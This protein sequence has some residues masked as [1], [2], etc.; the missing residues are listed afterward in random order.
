MILSVSLVLSI[1]YRRSL[2]PSAGLPR[3]TRVGHGA[4]L[5]EMALNVLRGRG[6]RGGGMPLEP[7]AIGEAD[8]DIFSC[9]ACSGRST[10][11]AAARG[12]TRLLPGSAPGGAF[13]FVGGLAGT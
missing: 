13:M 9:P 7:L 3:R 1:E 5:P 6:H 12:A 2:G 4:M 8:G 10:G 11:S